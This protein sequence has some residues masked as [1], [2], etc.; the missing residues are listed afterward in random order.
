VGLVQETTTGT[1]LW[2]SAFP[3]HLARGPQNRDADA[4]S[5]MVLKTHLNIWRCPRIAVNFR[6]RVCMRQDLEDTGTGDYQW[7]F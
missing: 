6:A 5:L 2:D 7:H 3:L 4:I 1:R